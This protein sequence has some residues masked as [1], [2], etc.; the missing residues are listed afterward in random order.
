MDAGHDSDRGVF[1]TLEGPDGAGKSSQQARLVD[2]LLAMGLEVVATREPGGT[3]LGERVRSVLLAA[4]GSSDPI[5]DAL[6]FNAAR[7]TLVGEVITPALDAGAVVVCDR[8]ADSTLA[9][10]GYGGGV[11][12]ETLRTLADIATGGLRPTRTVL[13]D[14]PAEAGLTRRRGGP[15]DQLTRFETSDEHGQSFHERVR[16]GYL[17][18]AA[19]EPDR[20]RVVDASGTPEEVGRLVWEAVRDL[21]AA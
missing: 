18:M 17:A 12:L 6:L 11:P 3:P 21:F 20:W 13:L 15:T 4:S 2:R 16:A 9:Y 19:D 1:I 8:F 14:L 10:Q 5:A 7:R